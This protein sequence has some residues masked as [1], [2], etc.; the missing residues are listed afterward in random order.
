MACIDATRGLD[1][2]AAANTTCLSFLVSGHGGQGGVL[3]PKVLKESPPKDRCE[4]GDSGL[5]ASDSSKT[6]IKY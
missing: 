3:V 5:P 1:G 4:Q 2:G 6:Y